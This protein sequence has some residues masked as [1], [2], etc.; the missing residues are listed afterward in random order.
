MP[1][2]SQERIREGLIKF[3]RTN[4]EIYAIYK[5][6]HLNEKRDCYYML[7]NNS[8]PGLEDRIIDLNKELFPNKPA[9]VFCLSID[10]DYISRYRFLKKCIYRKKI[11]LH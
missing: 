9:S 10:L 1:K 11:K 8:N 2:T 3:A 7:T 4:G 5:G 6:N